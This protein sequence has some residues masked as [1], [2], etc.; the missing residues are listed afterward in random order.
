MN[1]PTPELLV[2]KKM[3]SAHAVNAAEREFETLRF[4]RSEERGIFG[5]P[6]KKN[7]RLAGNAGCYAKSSRLQLAR[8]FVAINISSDEE[9]GLTPGYTPV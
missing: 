3:K 1:H 4:M 7:A 2:S 6:C 5:E 9:N 8:I